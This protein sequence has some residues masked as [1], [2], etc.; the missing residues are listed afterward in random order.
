MIKNVKV[1][2]ELFIPQFPHVVYNVTR[3]FKNGSFNTVDNRG[4][5]CRFD[6]DQ[7]IHFNHYMDSSFITEVENLLL[8]K[9][10]Y[11]SELQL[12]KYLSHRRIN[13]SS[14][15]IR[16]LTELSD[17]IVYNKK[18]GFGHVKCT[19]KINI[20][21]WY[22]YRKKMYINYCRDMKNFCGEIVY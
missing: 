18:L 15:W 12:V 4:N 17:N 9:N 16:H 13:F 19:R 8:T 1:G 10:V 2:M 20:Y 11:F 3:I 5:K 6:N 7:L 21:K 14:N 22:K